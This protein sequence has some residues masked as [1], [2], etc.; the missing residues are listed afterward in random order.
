M[1]MQKLNKSSCSVVKERSYAPGDSSSQ[2]FVFASIQVDPVHVTR[3]D[4][5]GRVKVGAAELFRHGQ[6]EEHVGL[7]SN[8]KD[9]DSCG[10]E[11]IAY[12]V[13]RLVVSHVHLYSG[14]ASQILGRKARGSKLAEGESS[15]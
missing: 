9:L 12:V 3:N 8:E 13:N 4:D 14:A 7:L 2:R 5:V 15:R 6:A 1:Q 11:Q 10:L